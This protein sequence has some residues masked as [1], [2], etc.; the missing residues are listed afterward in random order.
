MYTVNVPRLKGK[1][2]ERGYNITTL[3]HELGVTRN[4]LSSYLANPKTIPYD[5]ISL[6]AT[7][8]C[9]NSQEAAEIFFAQDFRAT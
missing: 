9:D 2:A 5:K 1:M 8:L 6:M 4:T 7:I 3:S